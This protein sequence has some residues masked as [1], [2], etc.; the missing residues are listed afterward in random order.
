LRQSLLMS[1]GSGMIFLTSPISLA[2]LLVAFLLLCSS[3][4]PWVTKKRG[5]IQ[6][7][8]EDD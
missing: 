2:M 7:A 1:S 3:V 8:S 6:E 4:I 5:D